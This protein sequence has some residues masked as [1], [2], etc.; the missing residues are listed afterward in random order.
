L[1]HF[2]GAFTVASGD[3][4]GV[5]VEESAFLEELVSGISQVVADAGDRRDQFGAGA[6]V[7]VLAEILVG[8]A[9]GG[10]RISGSVTM[11][12]NNA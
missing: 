1:E 6:Q 2:T 3:A 4:W 7:S 5:D 11:T 10:E 12:D 9:L 8:V